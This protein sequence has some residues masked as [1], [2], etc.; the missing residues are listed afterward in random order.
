MSSPAVYEAT[1]RPA[2]ITP[3][4]C[5]VRPAVVTRTAISRRPAG[6]ATGAVPAGGRVTQSSADTAGLLRA[7]AWVVDPGDRPAARD[8]PGRRPR[9]PGGGGEAC[10][11]RSTAAYSP[12]RT[13]RSRVSRF[14]ERLGRHNERFDVEEAVAKALQEGELDGV[15]PKVVGGR[16]APADHRALRGVPVIGGASGEIPGIPPGPKPAAGTGGGQ[17]TAADGLGLDHCRHPGIAPCALAA[18]HGPGHGVHRGRD[19]LPAVFAQVR[20]GV[21]EG[22]KVRESRATS[23]WKGG[24]AVTV[25]VAVAPLALPRS[26]RMASSIARRA[27]TFGMPAA[28]Q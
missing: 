12:Q 4:H 20:R 13:R 15:A 3:G 5:R 16:S 22:L 23:C 8:R 1:W 26:R 27:P 19:P 28:I 17:G 18:R 10:S 7:R 2:S 24:V 9:P 14:E 11:P 21:R 25:V 6:P